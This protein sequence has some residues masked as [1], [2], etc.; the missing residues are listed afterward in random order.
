MQPRGRKNIKFWGKRVLQLSVL[1][2][3][4]F[5][6]VY[7]ALGTYRSFT[8]FRMTKR[9]VVVIP[10]VVRDL[11]LSIPAYVA[12][13]EHPNNPQFAETLSYNHRIAGLS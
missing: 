2:K 9:R 7:A 4:G 3:W 6:G 8:A 1:C 10:N 12:L 11:Y 13:C 5:D